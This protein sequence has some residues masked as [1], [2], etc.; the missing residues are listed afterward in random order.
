[1]SDDLMKQADAISRDLMAMSRCEHSDLSIGGD[2]ADLIE[3][4]MNALLA[5][6]EAEAEAAS[7]IE[8][9]EKDVAAK[10]R[11]LFTSSNVIRSMDADLEVAREALERS[12]KLLAG[13]LLESAHSG[14][15]SIVCRIVACAVE[16]IEPALSRFSKPEGAGA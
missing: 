3:K 16:R 12:K 15:L 5:S 4:L 7:R 14:D 1:M 6:R 9:L 13:A 8:A 10:D 2:A 11:L